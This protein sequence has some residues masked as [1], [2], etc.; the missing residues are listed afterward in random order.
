MQGLVRV[1]QGVATCVYWGECSGRLLLSG[2]RLGAA[3]FLDVA[4]WSSSSFQHGPRKYV[5]FLAAARVGSLP[6]DPD[7]A[8]TDILR[9]GGGRLEGKGSKI[10][11]YY[12]FY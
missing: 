5:R 2:P 11:Y 9:V 10:I 12:Y 3:W 1:L 4:A 7:T 6:C 8:D